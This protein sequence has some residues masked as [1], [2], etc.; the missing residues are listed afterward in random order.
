MG[1]LGR[2]TRNGKKAAAR[3][4]ALGERSH[5]A[6][7]KLAD[8]LK[9]NKETLE[10]QAATADILRALSRS[11]SDP[12]PVF[13]AIVEHAHRLCGA[14]FSIL[15]R[16][17]G[18][19]MTVVA[20]RVNAKASRILR[21]LYPAPPRRDHIVGRAILDGRVVHSSDVP[22]D[23]RF[24]GNRNAFMKLVPFRAGLEVPLLRNGTVVGAIAVGRFEPKAF[25]KEEISL[26]QTFAD[27]A[28]IAMENV[29]LFNETKEALEQQTATS[30]ILRVISN[31]PTEIQ[32]VLDAVAATAARLCEAK[33]AIIQLR[34]GD[35]LRFAAHYGTIPNLPQG[36]TRAISRHMVTG[37]AILEGRQIHVHDLQAE[38]KEFPQGSAVA[39][40]FGYRTMLVTPLMR[41]GKAIGTILIRR[42]EVRP[43][44]D[45]HLALVRT[46]ADQAVIAIE[47]VRLFNETK[48]ALERQTAT[49]EVLR[50]ISQSQTDAQPVF[51]AIIHSAVRLCAGTY[52]HM[53]RV[54]GDML[55]L[56]AH[57][58]NSPEALEMLA[59]RYPAPLSETSLIALA[60]RTRSLV[61][62]PDTLN[63]PRAS[64]KTY[65]KALNL[66][67]Q[68]TVPLIKGDTVIG[69][70]NVQR[71]TPGPFS[72]EQLE[73]L[74][75]FADQ[76]VIAIENAR[77]FNETKEA[78]ERQTATGEILRVI[79]GTPADAQ[80]VFDAITQSA[81]RVFD[82]SHVGITV[83]EGDSIRS[84][85]TAGSADPRGEFV[86][87]LNR[88][89]TAGRCM[90]D[91][92]VINIGDTEAADAPSFARDSGRVV[93]FRAIAA[94]PMLR[95]GI[96]IGSVHMM[97]QEPGAFSDTQ[98][99]LLKT[100]ADQAVI[101]IENARLFNE[102]KE[103]LEQQTATAE[104]LKVISG[105]PT[106]TQPVFD[107][108]VQ[109]AAGLFSPCNVVIMM[110]EGDW[111]QRKANAGPRVSQI[112]QDQMAKLYPLPFDAHRSQA[113]RSIIERHIVE[114]PD[115]EAPECSERTRA[116][117]RAG[118][119]RSV[120][121]VPL[122]REG[123]GIGAIGLSHPE[124]GFKLTEKQLALL[125]TFADQA[126]IA[127]ENVR[128]FNET[129]EALEKQTA[130]AEI[131]RVISSSPTDT[132]PVFEAI[133]RNAT[134]LCEAVYANVFR[135]DG[136]MIH[137]QASHGWPS[138]LLTDLKK[139]FPMRPNPSRAAGRVVLS[140]QAV[141]LEDTRA[142]PEYDRALAEALSY[143][144]IL[145]VPLLR[146]GRVLGALMVGWSEPGPIEQ[147]HEDLLTTFADQA[148]IAI[149]NVRLFNETK[150]ALEQQTATAAILRVI[151]ST[152]TDTQPVFDAIVQ[153]AQRLMSGK[154]A[155]LLLRR[156]SEFFVAA[157][158]APGLEDVPAEVRTVPLDRDKNFPSRVILDAEVM[159]IRDWEAEDV[160]EH[161]KVVARA[162][163]IGSG[164]QVPL[165][166]E[167]QGIGALVITR[168][169]KGQF[170]EKEIALLRSFADQAVI[171]IENVRLFNETK[172]SLEQQT[173]SA[174]ILRVIS[175]T[176]TDIQPVFNAVAKSAMR[177][178]EGMEV[179]VAL[180]DGSDFEIK[181]T[182]VD[183]ARV[184]VGLRVPLDRSSAGG[185]SILDGIVL[186][187]ADTESP[188]TPPLTRQRARDI[189][190]R[191]FAAAPMLREGTA[192]G[193]IAVMRQR[194]VALNDKQ[195]ALLRTFADQAVIAIEN[196]RLFNQTRESLEQQTAIS[197]IL[198]VISS[199]PSDVQP[200]LD[201]V[202]E[203]AARICAAEYSDIVLVDS[204]GIRVAAGFG[205]I[206]RTARNEILPLDRSTV[207]GRSIVDRTTIHVANLLE[208]GE[209]FPRG[210][211][212]ALQFGHRSLVAVP[213]LRENR[214]LGTILVRRTE[215]RPFDEKHIALLKTFADQ[216]A[217]AIENVRLFNETKEA[218]E[219]QTAT[220]E[221]LR[222]ISQSQTD[223][224]PVFDAIVRSAVRLCAASFG[225]MLRVEDETIQLWAYDNPS[226]EAHKL[227]ALRFP[228]PVSEHS[229][230]ALAARTG[231]VV[232]SA[233]TSTDPR[234]QVGP[235]P[236]AI[237]VRAQL[238]VPLLREG[239]VVA[240]LNV[241][242]N[243]PGP[244]SA[245]QIEMLKTFADQAVIAIENVRLFDETKESLE[246]QTATAEILRVISSTPTDTQPVFDAIVQSAQHL[247]SGKSA[248]LLLRRETDFF[249]A[250][251]SVPGLES[252]PPEVRT[253][254]L[255]RDKNYPSRA[256]L[257]GKIVHVPDFEADDVIEFEK[258]VGKTY[259]VGSG[260]LVPLLRKGEGIGVLAVT[261]QTKGPFSEKEMALLQS[262]ADQAVIAIENVRL[263]KELQART[264]ALTKSVGQLTA[265]GEVGQ[266]I[267]STLDLETVLKTI[268]ARA[269]QLTGLDGG[270]IYEYDER[271]EEYHLRA[272][273]NFSEEIVEALRRTPIRR[274]EGPVWR[275]GVTGQP[276]EI[277]EML[278]ES[279]QTP[280]REFLVRAGYRALLVVP[281]LRE[282][283]II[284]ALAVSRKAP[285][286][287]APEVVE[288][289][290][291]FAT[292]SALAIQNARLFREI[293]EKGKQLEVASRHK[294]DFLASMSHELR[295]PLNALLGFNEMILGDIYGEVPADMQ[296]PLAQM[297][298]SGKHLLRLIN[299]VLD[300]AKIEAGRMELALS[301]YSVHDTVE[302]V[303]STLRPLAADKGLEFLAT[304]Q[305]EIPLAYGDA[306][307]ITQCLMNLAGNSLKFTKAGKVEISAALN[308]GWLRYRVADTGIGIPPEKLG[309]LFTEFKQTDATIASEYGGTGLGLSISKKFVEMHGG[310]IWVESEVGK[311]SVFIFEI[312]HRAKTA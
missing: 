112:D 92:T 234:S 1:T 248:I 172:E 293:A 207:M 10:Q 143:R 218:L 280:R 80:P 8:A 79:A 127:I 5:P 87:P 309:S 232:H 128:L 30:E 106:D 32:P 49:S 180:V 298:S 72:E 158:S 184:G 13:E 141:R 110:R 287:F 29:R 235:I 295:T 77:L 268:V 170:H 14:V 285:G 147:R 281:L 135:Y 303:R 99:E 155:A 203:R 108:I 119:Y 37:R 43:F 301:E 167:G 289:L 273:E 122:I 97:H 195:I 249:V 76:A 211:E 193:H 126:V 102:T 274:G 265:L 251:Y 153:S 231:E 114:I 183:H 3:R 216:A 239:K 297:Q 178:F 51:D 90:M 7:A 215:V 257:S 242:R 113:A 25:T 236:K 288:L 302:S 101:A 133:V 308:D 19:M 244:F 255:D 165:L 175:S 299:N 252:L 95:E 21:N 123:E 214:A 187:I 227:V 237:G 145:G 205:D 107:A 300:L 177:I 254:P 15:Y 269:V 11:S 262:F 294:S 230:V 266:A 241:A 166:R 50:V 192:I 16:Y 53:T 131:L 161:E 138:E 168:Q 258:F 181:A 213:L 140:G 173:A 182:S 120:T 283:H 296:P 220:A 24:P 243:T 31:S 55:H 151:S 33:D 70:L 199:S 312:P 307:R 212:L 267:S 191:A 27:Q 196:V 105:S 221:I 38:E 306:G 57:H 116:M 228:A 58:G 44:S 160:P 121:V 263:F 82:V 284:G 78:L 48:E 276:T 91:R 41:E 132:Q 45:K 96:A 63:D 259:G 137:W 164:L 26:L 264:E 292:Q 171:A 174:E 188:E 42:T 139:S 56:W 61:H 75:T 109:S 9:E 86:I 4:V 136:E 162:F 222:V 229:L 68:V 217:I 94:A 291:T 256:M 84:K 74:R 142:D 20:D 152:P 179:A 310:R 89:S 64:H 208:H 22:N 271:A 277:P 46:F 134:R 146:E 219:R 154:S 18:S 148:V 98:I 250:A 311:G 28:V 163:G 129:K 198:R 210:R 35:V 238:T 245:A 60:V 260:L 240:L 286:G 124:A 66:R 204:G 278:D 176:P 189:G 40:E 150:E 186:N 233:D 117:G 305:A 201:A 197:D 34:E 149:E 118:K 65:T 185:R 83:L 130:T 169:T 202:A 100:F 39:K 47:N 275:A 261:R 81:L 200:V 279:Y 62:S 226:P 103:A 115:T 52:G 290:K 67:A 225:A 93:G 209:D 12:Q 156:E 2:T 104:I 194:P 190:F 304:V 247:M 125:R 206:A 159:H 36:G 157:Y 282:N 54:D 59:A 223:T 111:L 23:P 17:D 6:I 69:A 270:S 71:D 253:A 272:S 88:D 73:L 85:A 144:K 224:Q 246:R